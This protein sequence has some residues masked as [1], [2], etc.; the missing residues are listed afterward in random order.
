MN[1]KNKQN[2]IC[3]FNCNFLRILIHSKINSKLRTPTVNELREKEFRY[4]VKEEARD[5]A[6][7][8]EGD[9]LCLIDAQLSPN[10]RQNL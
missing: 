5:G 10:E 9:I 2:R 6:A 4:K 7:V 8:S 3:C 1:N